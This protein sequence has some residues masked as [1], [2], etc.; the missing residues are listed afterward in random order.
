MG[1][2]KQAETKNVL[3][4]DGIDNSRRR[5]SEITKRSIM[6]NDQ[7]ILMTIQ[8]ELHAP[9]NQRNTF[10][11]YNYR[12]CEDILEAVKPLLAK[13]GTSLVVKDEIIERGGWL[14]IVAKV[15]LMKGAV[16][17]AEGQ[18]AARHADAQKGMDASQISGACSSYARKYA[19]NGLFL[20]DDNKDS[21]A[22]NRHETPQPEA[23]S[24]R[25]VAPAATRRAVP[26]VQPSVAPSVAPN[27]APSASP[28]AEGA[29]LGW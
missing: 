12:S 14:F 9:K 24:K 29:G 27:A 16:C 18:A 23:G 2:H 25:A 15:S 6:N 21:D 4:K 10:G 5:R 19:L 17:I 3:D 1:G 8:Q 11:N 7:D 20:I 28:V 13:T 22:T 26:P